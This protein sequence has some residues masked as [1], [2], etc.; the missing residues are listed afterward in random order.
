[1]K[2]VDIKIV[3][4]A[5]MVALAPLC[6]KAESGMDAARLLSR[7]KATLY[8]N[9]KEAASLANRALKLCDTSRPD[10]ICREATILYGNAEQLL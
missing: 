6:L 1:M 4:I 3:W 9:P 7:A 5:M 2:N 10:S 8:T